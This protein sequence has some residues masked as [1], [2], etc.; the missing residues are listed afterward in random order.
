[1]TAGRLPSEVVRSIPD[2]RARA[3]ATELLIPSAVDVAAGAE[4][5]GRV[6]EIFLGWDG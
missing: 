2:L 5:L 1:M 4:G 3:L 6:G